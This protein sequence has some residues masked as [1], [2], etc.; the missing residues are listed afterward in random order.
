M[1]SRAGVFLV[2]VTAPDPKTARKLAK[3]ALEDRLA[4]CAN[5]VPGVE[6][7]YWWEGKLTKDSEVLVLFKTTVSRLNALEELIISKHPYE[8][9]EFIAIPLSDGNKRYLDWIRESVI[10]PEKSRESAY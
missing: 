2:L 3:A 1:R 8:T 9:P 5:L 10:D 4:A 6:S 7:H